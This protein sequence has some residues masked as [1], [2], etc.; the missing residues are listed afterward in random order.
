ML[1]DPIHLRKNP[2]TPLITNEELLSLHLLLPL[3]STPF[4]QT[5]LEPKDVANDLRRDALLCTKAR[6]RHDARQDASDF[7]RA[8]E[9]EGRRVGE[10]G[11]VV[12]GEDVD[13]EV[14]VRVGELVEEFGRVRVVDA[15][16]E[17][18]GS[19]PDDF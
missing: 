1:N 8:F 3:R 16:P 11:A 4:L 17:T 18:E 19:G 12:R 15:V 13:G 9:S 2:Q 14:G 5:L 6:D 7:S 10:E